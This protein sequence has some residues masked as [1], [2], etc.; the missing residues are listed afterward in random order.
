MTG[1]GPRAIAGPE[2]VFEADG[3]I[4]GRGFVMKGIETVEFEHGPGRFDAIEPPTNLGILEES[5]RD[6][7]TPAWI[8]TLPDRLGA[9]PIPES[10][11][12]SDRHHDQDLIWSRC[13]GDRDRDRV[14]MSE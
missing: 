7:L 8:S 5:R 10:S 13:I 9:A 2:V 14:E 11:A 12:I 1:I 6:H 4:T 3:R